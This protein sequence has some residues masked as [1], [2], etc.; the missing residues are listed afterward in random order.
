MIHDF[1]KQLDCHERCIVSRLFTV[2]NS[3]AVVAVEEEVVVIHGIVVVC[4]I[5]RVRLSLGS[6]LGKEKFSPGIHIR[7]SLL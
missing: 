2:E 7:L 1:Y 4:I 3:N 6:C 5:W